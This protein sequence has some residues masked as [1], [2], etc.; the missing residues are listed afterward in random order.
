MSQVPSCA[1]AVPG[2]G[3]ART[4]KRKAAA[5]R[6]HRLTEPRTRSAQS[7]TVQRAPAPCAATDRGA[8]PL[9]ALLG[10]R[11]RKP[12]LSCELHQV[13][14]EAPRASNEGELLSPASPLALPAVRGPGAAKEVGQGC[15]GAAPRLGALLC[16]SWDVCPSPQVP[17][18]RAALTRSHCSTSAFLS[19][20]Q[21]PRLALGSKPPLESQC[22]PVEKSLC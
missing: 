20:S 4:S 11:P 6:A 14:G 3:P 21:V 8:A 18:S 17:T 5:R 2:G 16:V 12:G 22:P 13:P 19:C 7:S 1:H 15:L 10:G 9:L